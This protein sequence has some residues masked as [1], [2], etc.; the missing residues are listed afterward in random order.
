MNKE[1]ACVCVAQ[2]QKQKS[3]SLFNNIY[4]YIS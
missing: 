2:W 3:Q 4:K 1:P